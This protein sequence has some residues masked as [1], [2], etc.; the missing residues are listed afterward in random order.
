MQ[1]R[2]DAGDDVGVHAVANH[3][4]VLGVRTDLVHRRA[5]HHGVRLAHDVGLLAGG[6]GDEG[7]D[8]TRCGHRA[9]GARARGIRVGDDEA[10]PVTDET[11]GL[12][13]R[14]ERVVAGL[15]DDHV[16]GVALGHDEADLVQ[17]RRDA[18]LSDHERRTAGNLRV[19]EVRGGQR[20]GPQALLRH[21]EAR[22]LESGAQVAWR[23][24]RVVGE[25]EEGLVL[26]APLLQQ[27]ARPGDRPV[28]VDENSVHVG[29][30]ALD[31]RSLAHAAMVPARVVERVET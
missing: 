4:G 24:D 29:Q 28:L 6:L 31:I 10:R 13:D 22:C 14:L 21:L 1:A 25:H 9:L 20:R 3:A 11:D 17:R 8:G 18:S 26:V 16:V 30:P 12:G 27:G 5:E 19:Q 23:E 2:L 15:A 7:G